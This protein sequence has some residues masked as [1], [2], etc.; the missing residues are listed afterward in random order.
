MTFCIF[1]FKFNSCFPTLRGANWIAYCTCC[2]MNIIG[3]K[4]WTKSL[5]GLWVA[6][7][8]P[9]LFVRTLQESAAI[10]V[11]ESLKPFLGTTLKTFW[12][13]L[14]I[15]MPILRNP[16]SSITHRACA[17]FHTSIASVWRLYLELFE[18]NSSYKCLFVVGAAR[19]VLTSY[20]PVYRG[21]SDALTVQTLLSN[22]LTTRKT[23]T[24]IRQVVNRLIAYELRVK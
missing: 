18:E 13:F 7:N 2:Q 16:S 19:T 5:I 4:Q 21:A 23:C 20:L 17:G 9:R 8:A 24:N 12:Y 1:F 3:V 6:R 22:R 15:F 14:S 11:G 10:L